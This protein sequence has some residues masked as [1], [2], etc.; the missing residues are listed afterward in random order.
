MS[1]ADR[2]FSEQQRAM[3]EGDKLR[4]STLRLL[5]AMIKNRE[6]EKGRP[7]EEA[8]IIQAISSSCK[9][10]R[11]AIAQY[12]QGKREDL[13]QK[14]ESEL[15]I[16]EEFLPPQLSEEELFSKIEQAIRATEAASIKDM[17]KVMAHLMPE[18]AGRM[19]G[20][21]VSERVR[22]ALLKGR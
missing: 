14:E 5:R 1:L 9:Q 15:M 6:V 3:K 13:A 7:L 18:I 11:E 17:G 21:R 22:E 10:R 16:L 20:K 19:N 4:L 2:L 12:G 8:E